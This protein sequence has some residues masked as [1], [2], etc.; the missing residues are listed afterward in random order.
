VDEAELVRWYG[1]WQPWTPE[2]V[3]ELL[4]DWPHPWWIA[5]GYAL[6]ASRTPGHPPS[7][8][9]PAYKP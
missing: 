9:A 7:S 5:G 4:A 3:A 2:Q 8:T 6:D 1:E